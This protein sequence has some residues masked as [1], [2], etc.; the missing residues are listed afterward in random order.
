VGT[1]AAR[2]TWHTAQG[3]DSNGQELSY[4]G[5]MLLC[6]AVLMVLLVISGVKLN[7]GPGL[8]AENRLQVLCSGCER[9]F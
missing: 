5:N 6:A 2:A 4:V 9:N 8:E 3:R 7:P 1:W